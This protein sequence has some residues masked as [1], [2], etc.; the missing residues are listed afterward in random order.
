M[1]ELAVVVAMTVMVVMPNRGS[2]MLAVNGRRM[3][4]HGWHIDHPRRNANRAW[5]DQHRCGAS[6][7]H[8]RRARR[9]N[10]RRWRADNNRWS[11]HA[12]AEAQIGA[13]GGG[14]CD[15]NC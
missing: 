13:A 8:R 2:V 4:H 3:G 9:D 5:R 14:E 10:N 15:E 1:H 12:D 11:A 6:D 7:D